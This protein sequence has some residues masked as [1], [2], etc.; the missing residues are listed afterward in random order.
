MT[1]SYFIISGSSPSDDE[2]SVSTSSDIIINFDKKI[3]YWDGNIVIYKASDDSVVETIRVTSSQVLS[4]ES[5]LTSPDVFDEATN[6]FIINVK[7]TV[8]YISNS[9]GVEVTSKTTSEW[10]S[11]IQSNYNI[12]LNGGTHS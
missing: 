12:L 3:D 7:E 9:I 4:S 2:E 11:Y 5:I 8:P 1:D 10:A 6:Q